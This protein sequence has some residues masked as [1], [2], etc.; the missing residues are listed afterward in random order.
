MPAKKRGDKPKQAV[1]TPEPEKVAADEDSFS[2]S[3]LRLTQNFSDHVGV[4]KALLT[5]PVRKPGRQDFVRVRAGEDWRLETAVLELKE[6]RETYL[7]DP[8]L[9]AEL[10]GEISPKVL[11]TTVNRQGVVFLWP[12]RLPGEDGRIDEWNRSALE[13]ADMAQA[14]WVRVAANMSLGAYEVYTAT[15][16]IPEPE[17][18]DVKFED[19]LKTA[20]KDRYIRS[21]KH[22]VICRLRGEA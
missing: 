19:L 7:V 3:R 13:G 11:F 6:E 9:W 2:E 17:W 1:E 18:P 16:S 8:G 10:P 22:P 5:V 14:N 15:G 4:R 12:I 21:L 20:F